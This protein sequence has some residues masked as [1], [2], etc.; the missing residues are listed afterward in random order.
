MPGNATHGLPV[1]TFP[2]VCSDWGC[3]RD[4]PWTVLTEEARH[5]RPAPNSCTYKPLR[6][7]RIGELGS[8]VEVTRKFRVQSFH[9][10]RWKVLE[11]DARWFQ[12]TMSMLNSKC[13]LHIFIM[14]L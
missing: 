11:R 13:A 8:T 14:I 3:S 4:E 1:R 12:N 7:V 2:A 10:G 6:A 9:L 5:R